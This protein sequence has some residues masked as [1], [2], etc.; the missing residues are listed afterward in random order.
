M[1]AHCDE[2]GRIVFWTRDDAADPEVFETEFSNGDYLNRPEFDRYDPGDWVI[3]DGVAY[4]DPSP[5]TERAEAEAGL[6]RASWLIA[7]TM[8]DAMSAE[9]L[10]QMLK[11]F[12][13]WRERYEDEFEELGR[14]V[15]RLRNL[16]EEKK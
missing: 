16:E 12:S 15:A 13:S 4:A 10:G 5:E 3:R 6:A 14:L 7:A 1:R 8:C 2:D 11:T 9:S